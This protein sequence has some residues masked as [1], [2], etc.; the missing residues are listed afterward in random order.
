MQGNLL[1]LDFRHDLAF[2]GDQTFLER[3]D[4]A[5]QQV[6]HRSCAHTLSRCCGTPDAHTQPVSDLLQL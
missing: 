5:L 4:M 3:A 2:G 1:D 6:L